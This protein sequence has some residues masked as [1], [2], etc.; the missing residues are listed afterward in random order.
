ML[1][2]LSKIRITIEYDGKSWTAVSQDGVMGTGDTPME[3]LA[4]LRA[5]EITCKFQ[6]RM[7]PR[8]G[9]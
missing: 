7:Q 6:R 2:N 8:K 4:E 1:S 5:V 3:A 9:E